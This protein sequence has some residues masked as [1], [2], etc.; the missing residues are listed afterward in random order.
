MKKN[1]GKRSLLKK[2]KEDQD[3]RT[4]FNLLR[5]LAFVPEQDVTMLFEKIIQEPSFHPDLLEYATDYFKPTW[6]ESSDGKRALFKL[7][8]WNCFERFVAMKLAGEENGGIIWRE[9][10][11]TRIVCI[12]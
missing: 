2:L 7:E 4:S 10:V 5:A 11:L 8:Q 3:F 9:I 12:D 1:C 6:I